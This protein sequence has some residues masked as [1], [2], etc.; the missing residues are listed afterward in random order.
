MPQK[1]VRGRHVAEPERRRAEAEHRD[2]E[3][4]RDAAEEVGVDDRQRAQREEHRPRQAAQHR[5]EEREDEDEHLRDAEDLH[6]Q[7]ERARDLRERRLELVPV[8]ELA[9][10]PRASPGRA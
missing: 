7:P 1:I 9:L 4:R 10:A 8:E 6:V 3:D 5:E 2:H